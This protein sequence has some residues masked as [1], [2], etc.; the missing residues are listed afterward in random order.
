MEIKCLDPLGING[1]E[2]EANE[3]LEATLP[4]TWKGYSSL[5]MRGRQS[6]EFEG[7]LILITHDRIINVELK[8][9]S[10]KIFSNDGKW[11]VQFPDGRE[12]HRSNGVRQARRSAQI[13]A[14]KLKERLNNR[15]VPWV[16]YCVVLCGSATKDDLPSD[17]QEYVFT[18]EEFS[19]IGD[20]KV[21]KQ[22]FKDKTWTIK[23]KEDAPNK[24]LKQWDKIFSNN[25]AD[26]KAKNYSV[27]NYILQGKHLFQHRDGLYAEYQSQRSD[28]PNYKAIMRRWD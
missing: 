14:T 16:D 2:R 4:N 17:E 21:Y 3:K 5:E 20:D 24:N 23:R 22:Y 27:N 28:N 18:L 26:F 12:E 8:K 7:D 6:N 25:S 13:L 10:G 11:V 15:F 9:W 19:K 1:Y